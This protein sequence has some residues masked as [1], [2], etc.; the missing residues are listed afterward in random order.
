MELLPGAWLWPRDQ[1]DS[2]PW[3]S[4]V[5]M[6][7]YIVRLTQ[8]QRQDVQQMIS[9]GT[10]AARKLPHARV[11]LKADQSEYGPGWA[12]AQISE[13]LEISTSTLVRVRR[14]FAEQGL[15]AALNRRSLSRTHSRRLDGEHEAHLIALACSAPPDGRDHWSL[16]LLADRLVTLAVGEGA[17]Q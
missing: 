17:T 3:R 12:D 8:A 9:T 13:A 14:V 1:N 11:L 4:E 10:E 2:T 6:Q 7:K 16:R 15:H 5:L